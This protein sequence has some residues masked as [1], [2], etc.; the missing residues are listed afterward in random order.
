MTVS[1]ELSRYRLDLMG[2]H[3]VRWMGSGTAS[4]EEYTF[5]YGRGDENHELGAGFLYVR[6]S[7]P[8]S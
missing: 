1:S 8:S 2:V 3:K 6:E 4:A 5:L 7:Y